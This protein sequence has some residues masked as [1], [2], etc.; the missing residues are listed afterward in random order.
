VN[1]RLV[2][3]PGKRTRLEGSTWYEIEMAPEGYWQMWSDFMIHRIHARVLEPI[4]TDTEAVISVQA[5]TADS[6]LR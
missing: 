5:A 2:E 4:R 6:V 1:F 3:L